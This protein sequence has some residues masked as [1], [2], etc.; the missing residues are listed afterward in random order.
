[1]KLLKRQISSS[2]AT[3]VF[4]MCS[5]VSVASCSL[6]EGSGTADTTDAAVK[7]DTAKSV[8][9]EAAVNADA[10]EDGAYVPTKGDD[11]PIAFL[12]HLNKLPCEKVALVTPLKA[13]PGVLKV[14]C[15]LREGSTATKNYTIDTNTGK[16]FSQ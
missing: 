14:T 2:V 4:M 1:M 6:T 12:L 11:V 8:A 7:V 5:I 16:V 15:V 3:M 9:D 13:R 10:V